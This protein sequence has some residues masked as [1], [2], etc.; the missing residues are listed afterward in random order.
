M[1][2]WEHNQSAHALSFRPLSENGLAWRVLQAR[3]FTIIS[4]ALNQ[5]EGRE[6][7]LEKISALSSLTPLQVDVYIYTGN[8]GRR[9][10]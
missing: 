1:N 5:Y 4:I 8:G 6:D 9:V 2:Y 10:W 7:Q 3:P